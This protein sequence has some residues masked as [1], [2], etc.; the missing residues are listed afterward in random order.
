VLYRVPWKDGKMHGKG[1]HTTEK[2]N[3]VQDV[4]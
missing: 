3:N 1:S 4:T 2:C